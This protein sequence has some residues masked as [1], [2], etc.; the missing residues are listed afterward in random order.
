ML[1]SSCRSRDRARVQPDTGRLVLLLWKP[2]V[3][4]WAVDVAADKILPYV[5]GPLH[6]LSVDSHTFRHLLWSGIWTRS[7]FHQWA[8]WLLQYWMLVILQTL[9]TTTGTCSWENT[10]S[11]QIQ[12]NQSH[13]IHSAITSHVLNTNSQMGLNRSADKLVKIWSVQRGR[14]RDTCHH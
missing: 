13:F 6:S 5:S 1:S 2:V 9:F 11:S 14:S 8:D 7:A 4:F 3:C 10:C 12:V